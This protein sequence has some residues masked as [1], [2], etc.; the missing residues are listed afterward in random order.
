MNSVPGGWIE[1]QR[2]QNRGRF[3]MHQVGQ[4]IAPSILFPV[5]RSIQLP[6]TVDLYQMWTRGPKI[7]HYCVC[8]VH[9]M[10]PLLPLVVI[11]CHGV[12]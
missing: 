10:P 4:L 8:H 1:C 2:K 5:R 7:R 9:Y 12:T 3:S 6:S 11:P